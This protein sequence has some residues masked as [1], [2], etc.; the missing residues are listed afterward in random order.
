MRD[1]ADALTTV[2]EKVDK[3]ELAEV[4]NLGTGATRTILELAADVQRIYRTKYGVVIEQEDADIQLEVGMDNTS[5][6]HTFNW[7]PQFNHDDMIS[8]LIEFNL[9]ER[10]TL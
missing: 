1:V 9:V 5:F 3:I 4:Y 2:N 6:Y 10:G 8:S 7:E